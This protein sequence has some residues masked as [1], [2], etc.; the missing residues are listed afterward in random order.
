[1]SAGLDER[2]VRQRLERD[3]PNT[4]PDQPTAPVLVVLAR[5]FADAMVWLLTDG[6]PAVALGL[7]P[8]DETV[9]DA[10][11]RRPGQGLLDTGRGRLVL[12]ATLTGVAAFAAFL[13][14]AA[15]DT[16]TGQTMAFVTLV[17]AQLAYVYGVRTDGP[18]WRAPG[19]RLLVLAT[20]G[21]TAFIFSALAIEPLADALGLTALNAVQV[22]AGVGLA[23]VP[24]G[25]VE[26]AKAIHGSRSR[27][28]HKPSD[29][30]SA[31]P[32]NSP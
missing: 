5:Q 31:V 21:S 28:S 8:T 16:S 22:L 17:L 13:I 14:G 32:E 3:G 26:I 10:P 15:T 23:L 18:C 24:L 4:V 7:D 30:V 29:T 11:P 27:G 9:M 1:M 2:E 6:L 12:A 20:L 25:G 19:N